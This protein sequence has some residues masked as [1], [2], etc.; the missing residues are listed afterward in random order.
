MRSP[1]LTLLFFIGLIAAYH[2]WGYFG[3]FGYDDLHYAKL[4]LH[5]T[6]GSLDYSDHYAFRTTIIAL[7]ALSYGLFGMS[8]FSSALPALAVSIAILALVYALLKEKGTLTLVAGLALT[9]LPK[10]F[11]FYADK[12]MPDIYVALGLLG[13]LYAIH[14]YRYNSRQ[15]NPARFSLGVLCPRRPSR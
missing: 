2:N 11:I 9:T 8:D 5:F 10:W 15:N 4:A 3:H 14:E 6:N 13:A 12:L 7:T 1:V